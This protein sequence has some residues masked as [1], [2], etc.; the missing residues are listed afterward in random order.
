MMKIAQKCTHT[1]KFVNLSDFSHALTRL[2]LVS[3]FVFLITSL[4]F[5]PYTA[6]LQ[7]MAVVHPLFYLQSNQQ[8]G[9]QSQPSLLAVPDFVIEDGCSFISLTADSALVPP[10]SSPQPPFLIPS[11]QP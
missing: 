4:T 6:T 8:P 11:P 5:S 7:H 3:I 9:Q 1:P 2:I 10:S